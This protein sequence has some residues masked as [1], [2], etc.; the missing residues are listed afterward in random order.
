MEQS[1]E[2]WTGRWAGSTTCACCAHIRSMASPGPVGRAV[3]LSRLCPNAEVAGNISMLCAQ[4]VDVHAPSRAG[5][6]D[7]LLLAF[8]SITIN[9][10]Y[11]AEQRDFGGIETWQAAR[12]TST[13]N[14]SATCGYRSLGHAMTARPESRFGHGE[15]PDG[16]FKITT[17]QIAGESPKAP[18]ERW[19]NVAFQKSS[20]SEHVLNNTVYN[21]VRASAAGTAGRPE[22]VLGN[23]FQS[24]G[25]SVFRDADPR[26]A[27]PEMR[28][29]PA[30]GAIVLP[31]TPMPMLGMFLM[32][33]AQARAS[34]C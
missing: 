33:L 4:A 26:A 2:A 34:A 7:A 17:Q 8:S 5:S 30:L 15:L 21:F 16:A 13:T 32:T 29:M 28:R 20:A 12:P 31:W 27:P 24:M 25:A 18:P 3:T 6:T 1:M 23:V 14:I 10:R 19:P 9:G 11:A 22:Q